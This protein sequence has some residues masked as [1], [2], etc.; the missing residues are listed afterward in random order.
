MSLVET[1]PL[2]Q[3]TGGIAE[4][5]ELEDEEEEVVETVRFVANS[6]ELSLSAKERAT[7]GA[8][9]GAGKGVLTRP[10]SSSRA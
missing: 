7:E 10:P 8:G 5:P 2:D 6:C 4:P 3:S 1:R 9:R